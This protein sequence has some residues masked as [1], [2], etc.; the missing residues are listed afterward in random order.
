M[1]DQL[2]KCSRAVARHSASPLL[3]ERLRM[4]LPKIQTAD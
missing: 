1:F 4:I 3:E 2:F